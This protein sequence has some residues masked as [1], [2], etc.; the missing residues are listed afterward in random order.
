MAA[1]ERIQKILARAGVGS[2]RAVEEMIAAGRIRINGRT[3]ILGGRIDPTKDEVLV[4]GSRVPLD[5][6]LVHFLLNKPVGVVSTSSDP[7]GRPTV[8]DLIETEQR[9]WPVGRLDVDS[10]GALLVTNDGDLAQRLTHPRFQVPKTYL[11]EVRGDVGTAALKT[12][13]RGVEL[14]DGVTAPAEAH[15]V[16]KGEGRTLLEITIRE[17]RHRQVRRMCEAAGHPVDR[18]VRTAI[19]PLGLGRLKP[20]RSRR[21]APLE[22]SSLYQ[23]SGDE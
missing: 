5:S 18:L 1:G 15:I 10:E 3:A 8:V 14:D 22:V 2:R 19:G 9:V 6:S 4:D 21:L 7:D 16:E 20:G 12:L 13:R 23:A 17:G 11:A